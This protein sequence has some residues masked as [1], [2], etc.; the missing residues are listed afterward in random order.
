MSAGVPNWNKLMQMGKLPKEAR[1]N[2]P[3]L[4]QLDTAEAKLKAIQDGCCPEC[5]AKFFG[6]KQI[7]EP[8]VVTPEFTVKC[9]VEGCE[10]EATDRTEAMAGNKLRMHNRTHEVKTEETEV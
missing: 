7:E 10:Y 8:Q 9:P 5:R 6:G 3:A 2:V 1:G 4:T